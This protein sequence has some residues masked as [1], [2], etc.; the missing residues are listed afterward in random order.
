LRVTNIIDSFLAT[1]QSGGG[2]TSYNVVC[3]ESNNTPI[4][5][6]NNQLLVDLFVQPTKSIEFISLT[7]VITKTGVSFQQ[8]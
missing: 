7:V 1:V 8:A 6:D 4:I 2:V 5:I 3:D